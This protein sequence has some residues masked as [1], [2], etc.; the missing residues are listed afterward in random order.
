MVKVVNK[1]FV[2]RLNKALTEHYR[3]LTEPYRIMTS[4]VRGMPDFIIIGAQKC[5]TTSLY[6]Y[7]IRHPNIKPA[8]K[9]ELHFFDKYFDK[10]IDWYRSLF[11]VNQKNFIT[12]EAS[13]NYIF[14]LHTPQKIS[15][16]V[17]SVKLIVLL[18]NPVDR[19]YSHYAHNL[20]ANR[21]SLKKGKQEREVL[22]FEEAIK[23]E[24]ERLY[25]ERE[26]ILNNELY[27]SQS[28]MY[29]S[30]LA[31]G[32]YVEQLKRWLKFFTKEQFLIIESEKFYAEPAEKFREI[33]EF[34]NLPQW[35]LKEYDV[36]NSLQYQ[37]MDPDLRKYLV[38][39][40]KPHNKKLYEYL[41]VKFDW[42]K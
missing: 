42:D 17:P 29:Y 6:N 13:P 10:G 21:I 28:C 35:E 5:G 9:K 7:L 26:K 1:S 14:H 33:G 4:S 16:L 12:G 24:E 8:I 34:L 39:Y 2:K 40:F 36:Y 41:N 11:P 25:L 20:R 15:T 22:S 18:R 27:Y 30:Y 23:S 31:K 3:V 19:A 38:D 37:K 32:I